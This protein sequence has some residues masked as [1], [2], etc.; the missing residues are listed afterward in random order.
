MKLLIRDVEVI[1]TRRPSESHHSDVL[2]KD[3]RIV[4][5]GVDLPVTDARVV[6]GGGRYALPGL[7]NAHDHLYS[8]E[9]R[10]PV[11][12]LGLAGMRA[13]LDRRSVPQTVAVMLANGLSRLSE[14]IVIERDMGSIHA[15]NTD[16]ASIIEEGLAV[17]PVVL[18]AG[19]PIV[20]TG[21]HVYT[22][23]READGPW[24]CRTAVREQAKRSVKVIKVMASGGVSR[25]PD[26]DF[27]LAEFSPEELSAIVDESHRRDLPT[28]AHAFGLDAVHQAIVAGIDSIEHGV[29]ISRADLEAMAAAG[30]AYV[31][32]LSNMRRV[33]EIA[34]TK[35]E[36]TGT[37]PA[38]YDE[39]MEGVVEPHAD[40]FRAAVEAGVK[41]GLGTDSTGDYT[42]EL[43]A[44]SE[45]GMSVHRLIQAATLHGA[46]ICNVDAGVLEPG[47]LGSL[48]L[49][50]GDP[51]QDVTQ[52]TK[53][54][55]VVH[56][57][58]VLDSA[59]FT[60]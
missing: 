41:I 15:V 60:A 56:G 39:L 42:E 13:L 29:Q 43:I 51:R 7:V 21:G 50:N 20:M 38:R 40:T 26:E 58:R 18:A 28:A 2:I 4:E 8:H 37:G 3:G 1:D 59:W 22:F 19:R 25:Y 24:E 36:T 52:L 57:N 6:E 48:L 17:G 55:V 45:L 9:L 35:G 47:K 11:P 32:T 46:E 14:G 27:G 53:P 34:R 10:I 31:P 12:E 49:Y 33:A 44:M 30:T 5:V 16:V 23:G 54:D